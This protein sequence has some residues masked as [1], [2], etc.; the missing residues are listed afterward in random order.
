MDGATLRMQIVKSLLL[1]SAYVHLE[2]KIL[3]QPRGLQTTKKV[4]T[5]WSLLI[6]LLLFDN[7]HQ[8]NVI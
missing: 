6:K 2:R 4:K 1:L 8:N 3:C 7:V 5:Y